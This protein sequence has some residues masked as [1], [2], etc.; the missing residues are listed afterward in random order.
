MATQ[1][2]NVLQLYQPKSWSGLTTD[3]HL[4]AMFAEQPTLISTLMSRVFGLNQYVGMDYMLSMGN[5]EELPNDNDYEW[6]LK[7]DDEKALP[8]ISYT[9]S[10][11]ARPGF[12]KTIFT[13]ELAEKYFAYTDKLTFD[14][15]DIAVRVMAEPESNGTGWLYKVQLMD[16]DPNKFV[17]P[18]LLKTGR[19]VSKDY[20]PQERTLNKTYGETSYT[21]PF[22]MRNSLSFISKKYVV[23][24]NMHARPIAIDVMDPKSNKT[25]TIWTQ[26]AE[27]EYLVQWYKEKERCLWFSKSLKDRPR[28]LNIILPAFISSTSPK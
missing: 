9:A 2:L 1:N 11:P 5:E 27:W 28:P 15:R 8:I 6:F 23:P 13:I 22:K 3:N 20:S 4:G 26:Y 19:Q 16:P 10:D 17:P 21:S 7:G 12:N 24:G 14:D 18:A 25:T